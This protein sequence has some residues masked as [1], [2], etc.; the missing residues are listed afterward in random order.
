MS[1]NASAN[2][3]VTENSKTLQQAIKVCG[4]QAAL[5]RKLQQISGVKCYPQ[6]INEWRVRGVI[7]PYWVKPLSE[8]A[9]IPKE[10]ID[11]VLYAKSNEA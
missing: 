11:P 5:A 4:S 3:P 9:G 6:K 10:N 7:P 1:E 2:F 8:V